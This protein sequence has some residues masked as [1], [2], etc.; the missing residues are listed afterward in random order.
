MYSSRHKVFVYLL[1]CLPNAVLKI[2][3]RIGSDTNKV[4]GVFAFKKTERGDRYLVNNTGN[5]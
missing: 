3:T 5:C 4:D 2:K 1:I